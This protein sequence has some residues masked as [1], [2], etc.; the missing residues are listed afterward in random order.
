MRSLDC[1]KLL[2]QDTPDALVLAILCDFKQHF[3]QEIIGS[4]LKRLKTL[5]AK[6]K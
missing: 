4:I 6:D 1:Q 3:A 5:L 2:K